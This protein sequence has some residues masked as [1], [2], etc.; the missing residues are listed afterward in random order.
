MV[1]GSRKFEVVDL[2]LQSH[3]FYSN[4]EYATIII[5]HEEEVSIFACVAVQIF[6]LDDS[7]NIC[8]SIFSI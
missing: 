6:E 8:V 4:S 2:V 5:D 3:I 7:I 1:S